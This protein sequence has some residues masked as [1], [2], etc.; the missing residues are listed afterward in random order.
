AATPYFP[1]RSK[2]FAGGYRLS[3]RVRPPCC[4]RPGSDGRAGPATARSLFLHAHHPESEI[5]LALVGIEGNPG[6]GAAHTR[7]AEPGSAAQDTGGAEG[8]A[9]RV[10]RAVVL[11]IVTIPIA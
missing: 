7:P 3:A 2:R 10:G 11:V 9:G 6:R 5:R 8:G 4:S 1:A